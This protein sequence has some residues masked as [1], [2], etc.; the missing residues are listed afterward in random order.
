[1]QS[2]AALT[3]HAAARTGPGF[4]TDHLHATSLFTATSLRA[5]YTFKRWAN[6]FSQMLMDTGSLGW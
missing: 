2:A 3:G 1:M 4:L 6:G 5:P